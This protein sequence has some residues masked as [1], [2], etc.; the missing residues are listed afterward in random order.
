MILELMDHDPGDFDHVT[1]RAGHDVRYSIDASALRDELGW[2]PHHADFAEGLRS[3]I[4]W[5][6]ANEWWWAPLKDQVEAR[7][8]ERGQ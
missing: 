3:T 8:A 4:D 6:R 2:A 5:Y 7:Y 1:D